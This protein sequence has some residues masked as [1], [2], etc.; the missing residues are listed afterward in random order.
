M[1]SFKRNFKTQ[2]NIKNIVDELYKTFVEQKILNFEDQNLESKYNDFRL[3][4]N[5]YHD[6]IL[7]FEL[8]DEK[9][10]SK[11]AKDTAGLTLFFENNIDKYLYPER[12]LTKVY[13]CDDRNLSTKIAKCIGK[14]FS[15]DRLLSKFNKNS[16]LNLSIKDSIYYS[17]EN[18]GVL[19]DILKNGYNELGNKEK[20]FIYFNVLEKGEWITKGPDLPTGAEIIKVLDVLSPEPKPFKEVKGLVISDYQKVLEDNWLNILKDKYDVVINED[21]LLALKENN[22]NNYLSIFNESESD[23]NEIPVYKGS[24]QNAFIKASKELGVGNSIFFKWNNNIY[25]TELAP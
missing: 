9:V 20:S 7:L 3:L 2:E 22:L 8:M 18:A 4:I 21:L 25:T 17:Q 24:F 15:D 23:L 13:L 12:I 19:F 14:S 11:A 5:E 10:W 16:V 1:I 6:G